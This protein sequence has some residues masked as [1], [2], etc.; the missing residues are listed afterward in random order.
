M[1]AY[2][3]D[4]VTGTEWRTDKPAGEQRS[5]T[6]VPLGK[7]ASAPA[8]QTDREPDQTDQEPRAD[9]SDVLKQDVLGAVRFAVTKF[10][11]NRGAAPDLSD[12]DLD[13]AGKPVA[14]QSAKRADWLVPWY[15]AARDF[16]LFV[17]TRVAN[18]ISRRFAVPQWGWTVSGS[19]VLMWVVLIGAA[20]TAAAVTTVV[21][22]KRPAVD[23]VRAD[24]SGWREVVVTR[25]P[26][27]PSPKPDK[28]ITTTTPSR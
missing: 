13:I 22:D 2:K 12:I 27:P 24:L 19:S 14:E 4:D 8:F 18:F 16:Q 23:P 5:N 15:A 26:Q 20:M 17:G 3:N 28:W 11:T 6:D 1:F 10:V 21:L 9:G 25:D 7:A